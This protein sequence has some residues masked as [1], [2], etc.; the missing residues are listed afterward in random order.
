MAR[1][2]Q[3]A[4]GTGTF[5]MISLVNDKVKLVGVRCDGAVRGQYAFAPAN[6][7]LSDLNVDRWCRSTRRDLY[8][9]SR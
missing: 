3:Q 8:P 4:P 5:D 1:A 9:H 2:V 6:A 7:A